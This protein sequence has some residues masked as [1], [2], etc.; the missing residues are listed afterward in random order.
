MLYIGLWGKNEEIGFT[1][2][3][4]WERNKKKKKRNDEKLQMV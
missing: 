3:Y 2:F 4:N 1:L